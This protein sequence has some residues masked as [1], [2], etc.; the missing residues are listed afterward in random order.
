[1]VVIDTHA[2]V[3]A[4]LQP[5]RL[6]APARRAMA[7]EHG[8]LAASDVSFWE[9]AM[10]IAK[11][12]LDIAEDAVLFIEDLVHALELQVLPITPRIAVLARS[13]DFNH[14]DPA[15]RLIAATAIV[16]GAPLVSV[17]KK[18]RRVPGLRVLW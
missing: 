2:L 3:Q 17:D 13:D 14:G 16:H 15:D 10:L 11:R 12:R 18:L 5:G 4:A 7:G 6:S 1:M 9:I 8:P